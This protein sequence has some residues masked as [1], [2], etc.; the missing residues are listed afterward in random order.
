M[1]EILERKSGRVHAAITLRTT[2]SALLRF[3]QRHVLE[4]SLVYTDDYGSYGGPCAH[5]DHRV[6]RHTRKEYVREDCHTNG[7]KSLWTTFKRAYMGI[8]AP[9]TYS[10][11]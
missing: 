5:Y 2:K 7:I 4:R 3:I 1:V 11:T 8:Q 10:A 9:S 6:V